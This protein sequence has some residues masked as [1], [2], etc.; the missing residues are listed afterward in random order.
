MSRFR[1]LV[2][3]LL[4]AILTG[5]PPLLAAAGSVAGHAL[6]AGGRPLADLRIELVEA[7]QGR[8]LGRTLRA[9]LTDDRGAWSFR[10]VPAGEYVVRMVDRNRTV[11]VPVSVTTASG[12]AGVVIVAPSLV[13]AEGVPEAQVAGTAAAAA[14]GGG[15]AGALIGSALMIA[16]VVAGVTTVN[17]VSDRS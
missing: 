8:A 14:A 6:D 15:A 16:A 2:A 5:V 4:V 1:V 12:A 13:S 11:G 3:S 10:G 9:R 7:I 17:I